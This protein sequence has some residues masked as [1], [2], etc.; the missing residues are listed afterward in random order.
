MKGYKSAR[1]NYRSSIADVKTVGQLVCESKLSC[2]KKNRGLPEG[3]GRTTLLPL[4][5]YSLTC[6]ARSLRTNARPRN[7]RLRE[8]LRRHRLPWNR[9]RN[10]HRR[11][12]NCRFREKRRRN[13]HRRRLLRTTAARERYDKSVPDSKDS[14]GS[15]EPNRMENCEASAPNNLVLDDTPARN[16]RD[17]SRRSYRHCCDT[18]VRSRL[19]CS[20][21]ALADRRRR[22]MADGNRRS[23]EP[24]RVHWTQRSAASRMP[25]RCWR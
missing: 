3:E 14:C 11:P 20:Y 2:G 15:S 18:S 7:R 1:F 10:C 16:F 13:C 23:T 25:G 19:A 12:N 24:P 22:S 17:S 21:P 8:T 6:R 5:C 9:R 4:R